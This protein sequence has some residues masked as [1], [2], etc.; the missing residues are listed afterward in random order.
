MTAYEG[1]VYLRARYKDT[2]VSVKLVAAKTRVAPM[3]RQTIPK[4]ELCGAVLTAKLLTTVAED[5][6]LDTAKLYAWTNSSIIL[7]WLNS[8]PSRLK[9][10]VANH[11]GEIVSRVPAI[12]WRYVSTTLNPADCTS[13]G[14]LP[15]ELIE[16]ELWWD[17]PPSLKLSPD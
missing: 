4:L 2:T 6:N 7:G 15:K 12:Q 8:T 13:K 14:L 17:G 1:V 9:V 16:K 11:I 5:F 10:Y 3:K